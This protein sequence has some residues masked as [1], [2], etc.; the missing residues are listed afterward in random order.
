LFWKCPW[1]CIIV[2]LTNSPDGT[3]RRVRN[4]TVGTARKMCACNT[5]QPPSAHLGKGRFRPRCIPRPGLS[6]RGP[7]RGDFIPRTHDHGGFRARPGPP[8][9]GS[10]RAPSGHPSTMGA[11]VPALGPPDRGRLRSPSGHPSTRL[12]PWTV[13]KGSPLET[14][15]PS[16]RTTGARL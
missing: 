11:F 4:I 15:S 13:P 1:D 3:H 10:L 2:S 14:P 5:A 6:A 9:Q 12:S 7:D 8:D 16:F